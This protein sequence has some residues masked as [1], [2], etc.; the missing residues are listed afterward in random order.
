MIALVLV[1]GAAGFFVLGGHNLFVDRHGMPGNVPLP[2]G[3]TFKLMQN[4]NE[5]SGITAQDWYWTVA[6]P[7]N[8]TTL[9]SFY[10][11]NLASN[12]WTH[13]ETGG[14]TDSGAIEVDGCQPGRK[15]S[16]PTAGPDGA[17]WF[18]ESVAKIGRITPDGQIV[19]YV[20]PMLPPVGITVGPDKNLWF[21]EYIPSLNQN[22]IG[23]VTSGK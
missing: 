18:V 7:N 19:G 17:I 1:G 4:M 16:Y 3:A 5:G 21:T 14:P 15:V 23:S 13:I 22:G 12:G 2:N 10:Q 20:T 9:E 11:S 8:S 6:S